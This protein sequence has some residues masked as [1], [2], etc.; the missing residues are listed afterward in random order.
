MGSPGGGVDSGSSPS[1]GD[2]PGRGSDEDSRTSSKSDTSQRGMTG[3][4]RT[5]EESFNDALSDARNNRPGGPE[6]G[7]TTPGYSGPNPD[8]RGPA[9]SDRPDDRQN[10]DDNP[11]SPGPGGLPDGD[12]TPN[13][14]GPNPD[15]RGPALDGGD[16][17]RPEKYATPGFFESGLR[18]FLEGPVNFFDDLTSKPLGTLQEV[19][20]SL[21]PGGAAGGI[22]VGGIKGIGKIGG[23]L[24]D[25][26][27]S[28][29]TTRSGE[30]AVTITKSDGSIIDI[31]SSRVKEFVPEP[32]AEKGLRPVQFDD[33]IPGTKGK[34][35]SPT[36]EELDLLD[37]LT[38]QP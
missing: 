10:E 23:D 27:V 14:T 5:Q 3:S 4:E 22:L 24:A 7:D 16:D 30:D 32:R 12:T 34:K 18:A 13:Y 6:S 28:T 15:P 2:G 20:N 8:P 1:G 9:L 25:A 31:S 33:A 37:K 11:P 29:R 17:E 35:R 19:L 36:Q 21:G 38:R 26:L